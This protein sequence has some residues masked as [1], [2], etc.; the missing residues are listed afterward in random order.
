MAE[1]VELE[2]KVR[3]RAGKGAARAVRREGLVPGVIYGD[4]Q[5]PVLVSFGYQEL[6]KQVETGRLMSTLVEIRVGGDKI[7]A[8]ARDIQFEPVRDFLQH[9]D[10]LRLGK[11]ARITVEV[12]CKFIGEDDSP[13]LS[14]GGVLNV[15]RYEIEVNC[16][17]NAIPEEIEVDLSGLDI[18]DGAHGSSLKL[19]EGVELTITDRD[20]TICTIASPTVEAE[21][22]EEGEEEDVEA[23]EVP[24]VGDESGEEAS[25]D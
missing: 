23:G 9:V 13:G 25:E 4:K 8:I 1:I 14:R 12:P 19:P 18:G 15:V 21:P 20:F 10:F 17:A 2:A 11:G 24:T 22:S 16:P 7:R 5:D 6:M 3:E